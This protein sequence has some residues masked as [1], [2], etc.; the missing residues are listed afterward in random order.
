MLVVDFL[1]IDF[2]EAS[3]PD[4][5]SSCVVSF[6]SGLFHWL[7]RG[8]LACSTRPALGCSEPSSTASIGEIKG[9]L[10]T[11]AATE[12]SL[13]LQESGGPFEEVVHRKPELFHQLRSGR[14]RA[15]AVDSYDI[16]PV[17]HPAGPA[18]SGTSLD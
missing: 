1:L 15:E 10:Q 13:F 17:A 11:P 8:Y 9:R 4:L 5:A 2:A 18:Q 12:V 7:K 16:A 3:A 6:H 14:G